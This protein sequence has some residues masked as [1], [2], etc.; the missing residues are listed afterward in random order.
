MSG[1]NGPSTLYL[2]GSVDVSG[3][4]GT[5][6]SPTLTLALGAQYAE[7]AASEVGSLD[8]ARIY[9]RAL[10]AAEVKRLYELGATTR[11]AETVTSNPTLETGLVGHWTFDGPDTDWSSTT[12]EVRDR[13]GNGNHGNTRSAHSIQ[14]SV[15]SGVLGQAFEFGYDTTNEAIEVNS[16]ASIDDLTQWTICSWIY[17]RSFGTSAHDST[18]LTKYYLGFQLAD[19]EGPQTLYFSGPLF[20]GVEG[21]WRASDEVITLNTWQH[22]CATYDGTSVANNPSM[23]V[24][25]ASVAVTEYQAPTGTLESDVGGALWISEW[26]GGAGQSSFDGMLDDLRL[27]NRILSPTEVKRLYELGS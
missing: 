2:N 3:N 7:A 13:S 25:G 10:S 26:V 20:T 16:S 23:Y 19:D 4:S 11:I 6:Q 5:P 1:A 21:R 18:I 14:N 22:V 15:R 12:A 17:P 8:D 9:N 27:Y 24:N